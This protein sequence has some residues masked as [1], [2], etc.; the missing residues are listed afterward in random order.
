MRWNEAPDFR[1]HVLAF[2]TYLVAICFQFGHGREGGP[3]QRVSIRL[4][5]LPVLGSRNLANN[6]AEAPT[7]GTP[8]ILDGNPPD[9]RTG[10]SAACGR[11]GCDRKCRLE[12][13]MKGG[14]AR[15]LWR[16]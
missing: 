16:G 13:G 10:H 6:E 15:I 1:H 5:G 11:V 14:A 4:E 3:H 12:G 9:G 7:L 8:A 2:A